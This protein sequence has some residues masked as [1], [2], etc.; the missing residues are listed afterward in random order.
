[1]DFNIDI[2]GVVNA[3]EGT[4]AFRV[5]RALY[6][7]LPLI[8][9]PPN[10]ELDKQYQDKNKGAFTG[11]YAIV[12][13]PTKE[14]NTEYNIPQRQIKELGIRGSAYRAMYMGRYVYCPI[15][16]DGAI[17][18][19]CVVSVTGKKNIVRTPLIG[20][21][22]TAKELVNT[23]DWVFSLNGFIYSNSESDIAEQV[24]DD[25]LSQYQKQNSVEIRSVVTDLFYPNGVY[26]AVITEIDFPINNN[27][28][29]QYIPYTMKLESDKILE[30]EITQ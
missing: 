7:H 25:L 26:Q 11:D 19:P 9:I 15:Q 30:L 20:Q 29:M 4:E 27:T 12:D 23:E 13:Y 14:N 5:L 17:I 8:F 28:S 3:Q 18:P 6:N 1:M 22:G 2:S 10:S 24:M 21:G 16:I